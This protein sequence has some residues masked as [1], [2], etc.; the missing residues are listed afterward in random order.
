MCGEIITTFCWNIYVV[1]VLM[2]IMLEIESVVYPSNEEFIFN[3]N[4]T[5]V[6]SCLHLYRRFCCGLSGAWCCN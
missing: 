2:S 5:F 4:E 6:M 3:E 1:F